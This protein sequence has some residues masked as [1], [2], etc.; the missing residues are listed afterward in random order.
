MFRR[1]WLRY[2]IGVILGGA[3]GL[4]LTSTILPMALSA[5]G[6]GESFPIRWALADY[7]A[8]TVI[9]WAV[10]AWLVART[11]TPRTGA[12]ILGAAGLA[13]GALLC[14]LAFGTEPSWL[15][16]TAVAGGAYG[17]VGGL[18]LGHVLQTPATEPS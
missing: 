13:S 10:G 14:G 4:S 8:H 11:G 5:A 9:A 16:F 15:L 12:V 7:A 1:K 2:T 3:A 17:T 18:L 6:M